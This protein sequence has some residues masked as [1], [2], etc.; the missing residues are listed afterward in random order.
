MRKA[1]FLLSVLL[2]QGCYTNNSNQNNPPKW[3]G[4]GFYWGVYINNEDDYWRHHN[5]YYYQG[6][7]RNTNPGG[8]SGGAHSGSGGRGGGGHR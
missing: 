2:M 5:N 8:G 4:P 7:G 3:R 6:N 1:V